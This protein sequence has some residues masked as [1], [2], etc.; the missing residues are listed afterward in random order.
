V[1]KLLLYKYKV[2]VER[3]QW[4]VYFSRSSTN[5]FVLFSIN[6]R[7]TDSIGKTHRGRQQQP[8]VPTE[9]LRQ[10]RHV[11]S[12]LEPLLSTFL[13]IDT[14]THTSNSVHDYPQSLWATLLSSCV[15]WV[16][17]ITFINLMTFHY[18]ANESCTGR[19]LSGV[20]VFVCLSVHFS[21]DISIT[22]AAKINKLHTKMFHQESWKPIYFGVKRSRSRGTKNIAGMGH[23]TLMSAGFIWFIIFF[24]SILKN[25]RCNN[26]KTDL[27][28]HSAVI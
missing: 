4:G 5:L 20:Y 8:S 6:G 10:S 24:M 16:L 7:H 1:A 9:M 13:C 11:C 17:S 26:N 21:H 2:G 22:D 18:H 19:D 15:C 14:S 3:V 28:G 27:C 23:D 25:P 12:A